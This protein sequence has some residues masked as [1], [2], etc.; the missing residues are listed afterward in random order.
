MDIDGLFF[1]AEALTLG[2]TDSS[3]RRARLS[4][5]LIAVR[6][7]AYVTARYFHSLDSPQQHLLLARAMSDGTVLSHVS[8]AIAWG[9][10][11]WGL[12]LARPTHH[13]QDHSSTNGSRHQAGARGFHHA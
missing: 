12:P 10:D 3:L 7:G 8:A 4:G 2:F 5:E 11:V 9:M 6:P 13:D 1:R